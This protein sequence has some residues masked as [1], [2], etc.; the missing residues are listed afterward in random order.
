MSSRHTTHGTQ[1]KAN[2][3]AHPRPREPLPSPPYNPALRRPAHSLRI[4]ST[5]T[6]S[7]H[8]RLVTRDWS[9]LCRVDTSPPHRHAASGSR[10]AHPRP[11]EPLSSPARNSAFR[12]VQP[13][14]CVDSTHA[15][16]TCQIDRPTRNQA[17]STRHTQTHQPKKKPAYA[18]SQHLFDNLKIMLSRASH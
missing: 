10:V 2:L 17:V 1:S 8:T 11:C 16:H 6:P 18:G 4:D 3:G 5:H 15:V 9:P 14:P 12:G 13:S 7:A